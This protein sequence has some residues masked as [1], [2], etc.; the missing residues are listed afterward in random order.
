MQKSSESEAR[1]FL[2]RLN[3]KFLAESSLIVL[4]QKLYWSKLCLERNQNCSGPNTA[5]I[6]TVLGWRNIS[7]WNG[8]ET[9]PSKQQWNSYQ[10][11]KI[12]KHVKIT[13]YCYGLGLYPKTL[14]FVKIYEIYVDFCE[15]Q[16]FFLSVMT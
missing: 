2:S 7:S 5:K 4:F 6:S 3:E 11:W 14:K 9:D 12:V 16:L 10:A 1:Y 15:L 8:I 13:H